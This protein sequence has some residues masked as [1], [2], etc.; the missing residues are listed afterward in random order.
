VLRITEAG[1]RETRRAW[2]AVAD[3][4]VDNTEQRDDRCLVDLIFLARNRNLLALDNK[5]CMHSFG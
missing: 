5:T 2:T 4:A 3:V 1:S